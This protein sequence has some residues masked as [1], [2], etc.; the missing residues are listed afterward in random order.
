MGR[1]KKLHFRVEGEPQLNAN[2]LSQIQGHLH[3]IQ[4]ITN[5]SFLLLSHILVAAIVLLDMSFSRQEGIMRL[6]NI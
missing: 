2:S 5:D 4:T 6:N 3:L 1:I